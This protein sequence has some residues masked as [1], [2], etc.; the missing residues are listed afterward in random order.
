MA[1]PARVRIRRRKPWVF[2][3]RRLFGWYVRLLTAIYSYF[4]TTGGTDT[5]SVTAGRAAT[6][7]A[8]PRCTEG[9]TNRP[10]ITGTSSE[11]GTRGGVVKRDPNT[12]NR[13]RIGPTGPDK[14]ATRRT[15]SLLGPRPCGKAAKVVSVP[16]ATAREYRAPR[17]R[18]I[19]ATTRCRGPLTIL[20]GLP[21]TVDNP[22]G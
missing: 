16:A 10:A 17:S 19:R 12:P 7:T 6:P 4:E 9:S 2:A 15:A 18:S 14:I 22:C 13:T 3:R 20:P 8:R 21:T 1:R 5:A 11:Y